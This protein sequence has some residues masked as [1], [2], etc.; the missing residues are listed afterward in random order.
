M[1][2][3]RDRLRLELYTVNQ[4]LAIHL[5]TGAGAV[6]ATQRIVDRGTGAMVEELDSVLTWVR[7]GVSEPQAFRRAAELTPE[8]SVARTY[9]L[10]AAGGDGGVAPAR[11]PRAVCEGLRYARR[12][13]LGPM[14]TE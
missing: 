12:A 13:G 10:F 1:E 8:P 6:Q 2:D 5:R 14:A 7:S 11:A 4:M 3:R 9:K